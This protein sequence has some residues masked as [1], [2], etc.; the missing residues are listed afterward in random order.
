MSQ[1]LVTKEQW[2]STSVPQRVINCQF[3]GLE[4]KVGSKDWESL[5][6]DEMVALSGVDILGSLIGAK[7]IEFEVSELARQEEM[8]KRLAINRSIANDVLARILNKK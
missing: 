2:D 7:R 5:S 1:Y 6:M 8:E 4:G 3:V